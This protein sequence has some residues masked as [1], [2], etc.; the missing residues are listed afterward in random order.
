MPASL[1]M[2]YYDPDRD[3]QVGQ[4]TASSG[5]SGVRSERV[6]LPAVLTGDLAKAVVEQALARK[7]RSGDLLRLRVGPSRAALRPGDFIQIEG[8]ATVWT[9]RSVTIDG[10]AV[11]LEAQVAT[12]TV[13]PLPSDH[14]RAA[15]GVDEPIG[16]TELAL[17]E[18]PPAG[19]RPAELPIAYLAASSA[20]AWKPVPFEL[21][22]GAGALPG[23][24]VS[25]RALLGFAETVL[26]RRA[27]MV[28]DEQSSVVVRMAGDFAPLLNAD[29]DALMAGA[30]LAVLGDEL[31]QFGEAQELG[32]G[33]YRLTKLLRGRRGT[34]WAAAG[35]RIGEA[36]CMIDAALRMLE[37]P[38]SASQTPLLAT[39]HGVGDA[40]PLPV[41]ERTISGEAM[42]PLSPCHL[43]ARW[44]G[45]LLDLSWVR[46]SH[47][48]W[49][50]LDEVGV[51]ADDFG[52]A[53]RVTVEGPGGSLTVETVEPFISISGSD[54]P[55]GA[56]D[57]LNI[58]V[59]TVGS[60]AVSREISAT[61][62][63]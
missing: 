58:S 39:A 52:E 63:I 8:R 35:H 9:V 60:K 7:W 50:W 3:Y 24:G 15:T 49:A 30:N 13:L 6:E 41:A 44:T 36:F 2:S 20:G 38:A 19:D 42:R 47:R 45:N 40:A 1:A 57:A 5:A 37:L 51:P 21:T 26:E 16:R 43:T 31:I 32:S 22:L 61:L 23:A 10:L 12:A 59:T 53:Y 33:R 62:T 28:L 48:G 14:G 34:E 4:M 46:R 29:H 56:G 18:F 54:L 55:A 17:F 25:R 11:E 27:P